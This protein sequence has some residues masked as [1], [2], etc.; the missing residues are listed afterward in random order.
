[1][2]E[3]SPWTDRAACNGINTNLFVIDDKRHRRDVY[4][5]PFTRRKLADALDICT[6]CTVR[7]ECRDYMTGWPQ[8]PRDIVIAGLAPSQART[9]W[10]RANG[11]APHS[12]TR[13]TA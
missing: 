11:K 7:Q 9:V 1:M 6:G 8:P 2:T 10:I 5:S 3:R 12:H 13:R 4:S